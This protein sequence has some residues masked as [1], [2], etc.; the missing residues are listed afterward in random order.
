MTEVNK[1]KGGA[2]LN[3]LTWITFELA[4]EGT[5]TAIAKTDDGEMAATGATD[6][7]ARLALHER[8]R[9]LRAYGDPLR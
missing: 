6:R 5:W 7:E 3:G 8:L 1:N 2:K 4:S 9:K